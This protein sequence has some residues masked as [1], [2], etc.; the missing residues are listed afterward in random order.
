MSDARD[1][2][3]LEIWNYTGVVRRNCSGCGMLSVAPKK[4]VAV[5]NQQP[6]ISKA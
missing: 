4:S 1:T 6:R 5:A 2:K 3:I